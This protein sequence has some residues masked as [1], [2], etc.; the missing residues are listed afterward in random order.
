MKLF[1]FTSSTYLP[2]IALDGLQ[3]GDVPTTPN[4]GFNAV[5]LTTGYQSRHQKWT[6]NSRLNKSEIR[7]T[8]ELPDHD[9]LLVKWSDFAK[10]GVDRDFYRCLDISGGGLSDCWYIYRGTIPWEWV[11]AAKDTRTHRDLSLDVA[12]FSPDEIAGARNFSTRARAE[13]RKYLEEQ[14]K[15]A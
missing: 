1:H 5:W 13:L 8:V 6:A 15:S 9:P 11:T 12:Q 4:E 10:A 14:R 2:A 3:F 7:L